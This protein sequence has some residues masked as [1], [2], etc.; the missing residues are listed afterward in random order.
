MNRH[1]NTTL[2]IIL[3][4]II[5]ISLVLTYALIQ[6]S[7]SLFKTIKRVL[8]GINKEIKSAT[9]S[10]IVFSEQRML[11]LLWEGYKEEYLEPETW[12]TLDKQRNNITTSEG[13]SY[14]MLRSV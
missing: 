10:P 8:D 12:R 9:K 1:L 3:T 4:L 7:N 2:S 13:Q 11:Y 14:T 5:I 6:N